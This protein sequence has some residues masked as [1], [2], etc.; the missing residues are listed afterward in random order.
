MAAVPEYTICVASPITMVSAG[1]A[2]RRIF[3]TRACS[4][5]RP[6]IPAALRARMSRTRLSP[7]ARCPTG[8]RPAR[9]ARTGGHPR[10]INQSRPGGVDVDAPDVPGD[11][12]LRYEVIARRHFRAHEQHHVGV[13]QSPLACLLQDRDTERLRVR[14]RPYA[15]SRV[16]GEPRC[17]DALGD[18]AE[19]C[20][21]AHGAAA[22]ENHGPPGAR[23]DVRGFLD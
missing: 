8:F 5:S 10:R 11:L 18:V 23:E 14:L 3:H 12:E 9:A 7:S 16:A 1:S 6:V 15:F 17:A 2:L 19:R 4:F 22:D 13:G 20:P 21:R